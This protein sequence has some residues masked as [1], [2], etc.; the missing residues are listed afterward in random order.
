[1]PAGSS[2]HTVTV[3][4][5]FC[6]RGGDVGDFTGDR[7]PPDGQLEELLVDRRLAV[8]G[9]GAGFRCSADALVLAEL[10]GRRMFGHAGGL[11]G[12]CLL[13]QPAVAA[14]LMA[15]DNGDTG[16]MGRV[17]EAKSRH[18]TP[19]SR[20]IGSLT[21]DQRAAAVAGRGP[22]VIVAGAGTGKTTTV[23]ARI[24]NLVTR[25]DVAAGQVLAVTHSR[26]AAGELRDRLLTLSGPVGGPADLSGVVAKTFHAAALSQLRTV[27][28]TLDRPGDG[29]KVANSPY[30]YVRAALDE[31]L[32]RP[33]GGHDGAVV[34]DVLAELSWA[35]VS[36][37]DAAGYVAAA[38]RAGRVCP[39]T[40]TQ[41]TDVIDAYRDAKA[42]DGVH[43]FDD[44]LR[45]M[46]ELLLADPV[47][48]GRF[49][50]RWSCFVVDEY[51]D[52][53]PAQQRLLDAWLG[54]R[55][56]ITVVGD[57]RQAIY[58]FKGGDPTFLTR[59]A[60]R[61]PAAQVLEL[62]DNFRSSPQVV[63]VANHLDARIDIGVGSHRGLVGHN[64]DGPD[65]VLRVHGTEDAE[66]RAVIAQVSDWIAD[67]IPTSEIAV[68][69]RFNSQTARF[70]AGFADAGIS[71]TVRNEDRFFERPEVLAI[72]KPFGIEAREHPDANGLTLLYDAANRAGWFREHPPAGVGAVRA[73]WE[74]Q[75]ALIEIAEALPG[76]VTLGAR[77]LLDEL[78]YRA[79]EAHDPTTSGVTIATIHAAK[80]LEWDAVVLPCWTEGSLPSAFA[81]TPELIDG[82][83]RLAYVAVTRART[84]LVVSHATTRPAPAG[85]GD[86]WNTRPS[87]F[88]TEI[89]P[90]TSR[91]QPAK[92]GRR[93]S[94]T[95][96]G[97][98]PADTT[99]RAAATASV[100]TDLPRSSGCRGCGERLRGPYTR[101]LGSCAGCATGTERG[102]LDVVHAWRAARAAARGV[103]VDQVAA[104][105]A[106]VGV[107]VTAPA[108]PAALT[109]ISRFKERDPAALA[110][111][112]AALAT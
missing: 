106:C 73:R 81:K 75:L 110:A 57:P 93:A 96:T 87:Q 16:T 12:R 39:I 13:R 4:V 97:R 79:K 34:T 77:W 45:D 99:G 54:D 82:E 49:R 91:R 86:T 22:V 27:W 68:L 10:T 24:A 70:E 98:R 72:L 74:A 60:N 40:V 85:K 11:S 41:M 112:L 76:A 101:R 23:V 7:P 71:T 48:A 90:T 20:L 37:V 100:S 89:F 31:V 29:P 52:T 36:L 61:F 32:G 51:Q 83:R 109:A 56:D 107:V 28:P 84:H 65:P 78:L 50:R 59:F 111:L 2:V 67:G 55:S 18:D 42:A 14:G 15:A 47:L 62:R 8:D 64:A 66:T 94:G 46:A 1:M 92:T 6:V 21:D 95:G 44:L 43:D 19:L 102:R 105:E 30:P 88:L 69:V 25:G 17:N 53:D 108:T 5:R 104:D 35:N 9:G 103:P 38:S 63:T 58:G 33:R 3:R 26:K 80:G